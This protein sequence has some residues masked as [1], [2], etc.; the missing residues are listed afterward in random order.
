M[1]KNKPQCNGKLSPLPGSMLLEKGDF[2]GGRDRIQTPVFFQLVL[3][4]KHNGRIFTRY[5]VNASENGD[6]NRGG[7]SIIIQ[8]LKFWLERRKKL[9]GHGPT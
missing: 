4:T 3:D 9:K 5:P 6:F 8:C 7:K 1:N 2:S